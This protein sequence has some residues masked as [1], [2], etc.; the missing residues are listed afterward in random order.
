[1]PSPTTPSPARRTYDAMQALRAGRITPDEY[2]AIMRDAR[3]QAGS[4]DAWNRAKFTAMAND[5]R[6]A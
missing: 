4:D 6:N 3:A 2:R 1:M 5:A